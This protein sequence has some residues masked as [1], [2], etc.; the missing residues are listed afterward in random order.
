MNWLKL[1]FPFGC[2]SFRLLVLNVYLIQTVSLSLKID[3]FRDNKKKTLKTCKAQKKH[4][5]QA[6]QKNL[7][8]K[9]T[10]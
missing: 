1:D 6:N 2:F 8:E 5:I 10:H 4:S 9:Q 7:Y 3:R